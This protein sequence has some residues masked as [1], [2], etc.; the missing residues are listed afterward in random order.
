MQNA[1]V[2]FLHNFVN[3]YALFWSRHKI[4]LQRYF[5]QKAVIIPIFGREDE[6]P[7]SKDSHVMRA[8]PISV[9]LH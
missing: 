6:L 7:R 3:R 2:R 5:A 1:I 8:K 9:C 4:D